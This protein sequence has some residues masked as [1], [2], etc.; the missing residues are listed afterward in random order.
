MIAHQDTTKP[1]RVNRK[2]KRCW[3]R[4]VKIAG[5]TGCYRAATIAPLSPHEIAG[6]RTT[7]IGQNKRP[8]SITVFLCP[9]KT[10]T[11]LFRLL[12]IMAGC[13]EQLLI[14]LAGSYAGSANLIHSATQR[15]APVAG[16]TPL[17]IGLP[18]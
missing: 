16:G 4:P 5:L 11:G 9:P 10:Q 13:I 1:S 8:F 3:K 2:L 17:Y 7:D 18:S 15:L 6:T 12:F 14:E